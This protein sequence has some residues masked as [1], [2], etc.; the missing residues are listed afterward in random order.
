M[1]YVRTMADRFWRNGRLHGE[2]MMEII[3]ELKIVEEEKGNG[4]A[5]S[6]AHVADHVAVREAITEGL[7]QHSA[8][9]KAEQNLPTAMQKSIWS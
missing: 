6:S 1:E 3:A 5:E 8:Q 7:L 2:E 4:N 9:H